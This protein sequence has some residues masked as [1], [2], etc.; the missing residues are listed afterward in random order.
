LGAQLLVAAALPDGTQ[1]CRE[2]LQLAQQAH[3]DNDEE[4][5]KATEQQKSILETRNRMQGNTPL[6]VACHHGVL[7]TVQLLLCQ[8]NADL[9]ALNQSGGHSPLMLAAM[10]G[11]CAVATLLLASGADVTVRAQYCQSTALVLAAQRGM[12]QSVALLL[13]AKAQL[14]SRNGAQRTALMAAAHL[15][16]A[17][18]VRVLAQRGAQLDARIAHNNDTALSFACVRNHVDG[19]R[20]LLEARADCDIRNRFTGSTVLM[21][22]AAAGNAAICALLLDASKTQG[23]G[24]DDVVNETSAV[25]GRAALSCAA[26]YGRDN[27]V[28][29]LLRRRA[30]ADARDTAGKTALDWAAASQFCS[31][32]TQGILEACAANRAACQAFREGHVNSAAS[33][34]AAAAASTSA[35]AANPSWTAS[36]LFDKQLLHVI[37]SYVTL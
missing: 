21:Q 37:T 3:K 9:E 18:C 23:K 24:S 2:L 27:V 14:E 17:A 36:P 29:L 5:E 19:V 30:C 33:A 35:S 8:C 26:E 11:H 15:G 32:E 28:S 25:N 12:P 1:R 4:D 16:R 20:A 34:A 31:P 13:D 10:R 22:A 6:H 7:S